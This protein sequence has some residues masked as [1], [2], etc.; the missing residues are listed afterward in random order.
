MLKLATEENIRFYEHLLYPLQDEICSLIQ[1]DNFYLSGGTC[2]SRFYY[3][4]RYS[5]D[6][7]FFYDGLAGS[8]EGFSIESRDILAR[9]SQKY[10]IEIEID[11]EYFKRAYIHNSGTVLKI[12]FVFEN[13]K[14]I[15]K[16]DKING[17]Y[18]DSKENLCANKLTAVY[19]RK[20]FKDFVDLYY[21]MNDFSF[22]QAVLWAKEKM[23]LLDYE[24]L[25]IVFADKALEGE[26]LLTKNINDDDFNSF[27]TK[28]IGHLFQ[29]AEN[30]R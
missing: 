15:G 18:I 12:E 3:H 24:G 6:L 8:K 23:T 28:L 11:R 25:S 1:N 2:L 13:Y 26:V 30:T 21:L 4:H 14:N 29:H 17:I 20:T 7:D 10:R 9:I 16:R 5:D 19:D 27:K 22:D